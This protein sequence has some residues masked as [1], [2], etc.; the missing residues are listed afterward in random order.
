MTDKE[1]KPCPFCGSKAKLIQRP[2]GLFEI[3]CFDMMC[4]AWKCT[5]IECEDCN[6]GYDNEDD[7]IKLWNT[8]PIEDSK[9]ERIKELEEKIKELLL[10]CAECGNRLS[11][12]EMARKDYD[13]YCDKCMG[14]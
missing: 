4:Q 2:N 13:V 8:R 10:P 9:D 7:C 1:L 12:E 6:S 11:F 5:D 14:I 3:G